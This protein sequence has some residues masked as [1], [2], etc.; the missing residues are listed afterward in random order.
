MAKCNQM[1]SLPFKRLN[2]VGHSLP[3]QTELFVDNSCS[4]KQEL[5][6]EPLIVCRI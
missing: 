3:S 2:E 1:S 6:G 5:D 4:V